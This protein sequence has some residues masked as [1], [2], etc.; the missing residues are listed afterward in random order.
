M[1]TSSSYPGPTRRPP[2][3]PPWAE[4][5]LPPTAPVPPDLAPPPGLPPEMPPDAVPP[6]EMPPRP[7]PD[8]GPKIA[9]D[10][11][12]VEP[13]S[14][15]FPATFRGPKA[16][17]GKLVG[18]GGVGA[19]RSS[20]RSYVRASGGPRGAARTAVAG[21][22]ATVRL[23]G[24][25]GTV[26]QGGVLRAA[27]SLGLTNL[28]GRDAQFVLAAFVDALAPAGALREEAIARKAV[29]DTL[30][31][32]FDRFDVEHQGV[33]VLDTMSGEDVAAIV[34]LSVVNYVNARFQE[35]LVA[36][37]E[38]GAVSERDANIFAT[39]IRDYIAANVRLDLQGVDV[40]R[41]DWNGAQGRTFVDQQY[42]RAYEILG[43]AQ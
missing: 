37:I 38:R 8:G 43:D 21:R 31:E 42:L 24:F 1:G 28:L 26:S 22:R 18:G 7:V 30:S 20:A 41:M 34:G 19:I 33:Q 39:Q 15:D 27:A 35:E 11:R 16:A 10:Y 5:P 29:I 14:P 40:V 23:G 12:P 3:L 4:D 25:L 17:L 9:V 32:L 13:I 6:V 2:L 36:R